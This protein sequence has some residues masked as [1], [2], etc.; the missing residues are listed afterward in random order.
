MIQKLKKRFCYEYPRPA[1]T[2]DAVIVREDQKVLLIRRKHPP[3]EGCWALPGGFVDEKETLEQALIRETFEETGIL[4]ENFGLAGV[5]S[6][7]DRDPR[8]RTISVVYISFVGEKQTAV[9]GDDAGEVG[10]FCLDDLPEL[11]FDHRQILNDVVRLF[12]KQVDGC[13]DDIS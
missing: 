9:A 7:P 8:H 13:V 2:V 1:V 12:Q 3:F 10:W 6:N 5:Y 4:L 11:A